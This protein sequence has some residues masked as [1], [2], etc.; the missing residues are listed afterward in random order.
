MSLLAVPPELI[1]QVADKVT[2][3]KN[4]SSLAQTCHLLHD[5]ANPRLYRRNPRALFWAA[6]HGGDDTARRCL[7]YG[8]D[9]NA[10]NGD[11]LTP[12]AIAAV[13]DD[14][15]LV[16]I[17]L[18]QPGADPNGSI[19]NGRTLLSLAA[20][21]NSTSVVKLL[22]A[23]HDVDV[24]TPDDIGATPLWY[25]AW[26]GRPSTVRL[27][28]SAGKANANTIAIPPPFYAEGDDEEEFYEDFT[29]PM[30][31]CY[32]A[33]Q[34]LEL[35]FDEDLWG[36]LP[37]L[38]DEGSK[39]ER[40][41]AIALLLGEPDLLFPQWHD[42]LS[43]TAHHGPA[44]IAR[45]LIDRPEATEQ[46]RRDVNGTSRLFHWASMRGQAGVVE[47]LV[48]FGVDVDRRGERGRT[49]LSVAAEYTSQPRLLRRLIESGAE[50]E[51]EDDD[52]CTPLYYAI[53]SGTRGN[54][55]ELTLH[56]AE[57]SRVNQDQMAGLVRYAAEQGHVATLQYLLDMGVDL[58]I[59]YHSG[60]RT[61][62]AYAAIHRQ[63]EAAAWLAQQE[64]I[65]VNYQDNGEGFTS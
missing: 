48:D 43:H 20:E 57:L 26:C 29:V 25:A 8:A 9:I 62:L 15:S 36:Y 11:G 27:L 49:A 12:V 18:A 23:R 50:L 21:K 34:K 61:P 30:S 33:F 2:A 1:L 40:E 64:G 17:L 35:K 13:K 58:N 54:V 46:L 24:D 16:K 51:S 53:W 19:L 47:L 44:E 3:E 55:E 14:D 31:I 56:G 52:G 65:D 59:T 28:L 60:G 63:A 39:R 7:S 38:P 32:A 42:L 41:K 5:I 10:R 22:L 4:L 45:L 37:F 6:E